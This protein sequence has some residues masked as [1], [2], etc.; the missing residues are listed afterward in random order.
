MHVI[1]IKYI[2]KLNNICFDMPRQSFYCFCSVL[3]VLYLTWQLFVGSFIQFGKDFC[4][5]GWNNS[6]W[7]KLIESGRGNYDILWSIMKGT[8]RFICE[9]NNKIRILWVSIVLQFKYKTIQKLGALTTFLIPFAIFLRKW[10]QSKTISS[11]TYLMG[12]SML[13]ALLPPAKINLCSSKFVSNKRQMTYKLPFGIHLRFKR[14][15]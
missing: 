7:I 6:F 4:T 11:N 5:E 15:N 13:V 9:T 2:A 3:F 8:C 10:K 1:C 14:V 12:I